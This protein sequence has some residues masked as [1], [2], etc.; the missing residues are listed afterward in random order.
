MLTDRIVPIRY[1][2]D[3]NATFN[4]AK[5]TGTDPIENVAVHATAKF[6]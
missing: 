5:R 1:A 3:C 6:M 4:A 2:I